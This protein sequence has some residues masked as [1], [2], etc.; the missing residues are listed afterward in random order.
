MFSTT[1]PSYLILAGI[2]FGTDFLRRK[3][4]A[5]R[6][7]ISGW[8]RELFGGFD[9]EPSDFL[10]LVWNVRGAGLSGREAEAMLNDR[11]IYPEFSDEDRVVFFLG[12]ETGRR[13]LKTLA[14][15]MR[16]ILRGRTIRSEEERREEAAEPEHGEIAMPYSAA[17][18]ADRELVPLGAAAGRVAA[19]NTGFYPPADAYLIAGERVTAEKAGKLSENLAHTFGLVQG[20]IWVVRE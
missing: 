3:G 18:R 20:K 15:A 11:E 13:D 6:R 2:E 7:R 8:K 16:R 9:L 1:S 17:R 14:R 19:Q 5:R 10:R 4:E 12:L